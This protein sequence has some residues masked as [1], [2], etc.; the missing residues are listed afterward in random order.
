MNDAIDSA[1]VSY[2]R[3]KTYM[4]AI[5]SSV[6][7]TLILISGIFV[8]YN[9]RKNKNKYMQ[10][11]AIVTKNI[12]IGRNNYDV[13]VSYKVGGVAYENKIMSNY[14]T[15]G[16]N[17]AIYYDTTNPNSITTT[18]NNTQQLLGFGLIVVAIIMCIFVSYNAYMV[19]SSDIA[20]SNAAFSTSYNGYTGYNNYNRP[21]F[22][23]NI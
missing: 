18:S 22:S 1:V 17:M 21:L 20:A 23:L 2:G 6:V 7:L 15:V 13:Y 11:N 12:G 5:V 3:T 19:K 14:R 16:S 4:T 9:A 8:L 10:T